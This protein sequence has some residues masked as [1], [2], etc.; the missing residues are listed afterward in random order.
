MESMP[1]SASRIEIGVEI[2]GAYPVRSLT[3]ATSTSK[4][5]SETEACSNRDAVTI[6][7]VAVR[8]V[9]IDGVAIG[10]VTFTACPL[11]RDHSRVTIGTMPS[12]ALTIGSVTVHRVTVGTMP[13][14]A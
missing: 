4:G 2:S 10:A 8:T 13:F 7:R 6:H 3:V 1:R 14:I 5:S 12:S 9:A 11:V